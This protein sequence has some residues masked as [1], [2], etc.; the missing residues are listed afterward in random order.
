MVKYGF[1]IT[2]GKIFDT[3]IQSFKVKKVLDG[4]N[5]IYTMVP[6][7]Y[8]RLYLFE[9]LL[10]VYPI[11]KVFRILDFNKFLRKQR[12]YDGLENK[13]HYMANATVIYNYPPTFLTKRKFNLY[14][15]CQHLQ[16]KVDECNESA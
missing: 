8:K 13:T 10:T 4:E 9:A 11:E 14:K 16:K 15:I 12:E 7:Y 1:K 5:V 2:D 3:K 6:D